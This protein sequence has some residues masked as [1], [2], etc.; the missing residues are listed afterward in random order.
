MYFLDTDIPSENGY[1]IRQRHYEE[2]Y[3]SRLHWHGFVELEFVVSGSAVYKFGE[4]EVPLSRGDV[5]LL[6]VYDSHLVVCGQ[7]LT[8]VNIAIKPEVLNEKLISD[9][10]AVHPLHCRW[11]EENIEGV[12]DTVRALFREQEEPDDYS[13]VKA[14]SLLNALAVDL[15]R[16]AQPRLPVQDLGVIQEV[17]VLS[18][19]KIPMISRSRMLI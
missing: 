18:A 13:A 17:V 6:S 14:A 8:M 1:I 3:I 7:G 9:L 15:L 5:W 19:S 12:M 10:N 16:N 4:T 2:T 11:K